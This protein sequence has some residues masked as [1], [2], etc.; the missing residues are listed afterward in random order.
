M[1]TRSW[2]SITAALALA[3]ALFIPSA[4]SDDGG[5]TWPAYVTESYAQFFA[6]MAL[7]DPDP[8]AR[9]LHAQRARN[10]LGLALFK[11]GELTR[12]EEIYRSLIED[13]PS[14]L[15]QREGHGCSSAR[16]P[17]SIIYTTSSSPRSAGRDTTCTCSP[18]ALR[19]SDCPT[20][21]LVTPTSAA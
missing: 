19:S 16:T 13:H 9:D 3:S 11:I 7:I 14:D 10:L 4:R 18:A 2:I 12:A 21:N 17:A 15:A 5:I 1:V 6:F 8:V 20:P